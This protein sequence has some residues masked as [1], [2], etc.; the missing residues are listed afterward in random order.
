MSLAIAVIL[1]ASMVPNAP[2]RA[3]IGGK[4]FANFA[5][6]NL[7]E[8]NKLVLVDTDGNT[9]EVASIK[10][11]D[12]SSWKPG[13]VLR[14]VTY[15]QTRT[16]KS[17]GTGGVTF[18]GASGGTLKDSKTTFEDLVGGYLPIEYASGPESLED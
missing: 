7:D 5:N 9:K 2:K 18:M 16:L 3:F 14:D 4:E 12:V 17:V 8:S 6:F 15:G 13:R 11:E 1:T 10:T